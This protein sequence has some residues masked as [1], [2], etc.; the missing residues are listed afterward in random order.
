MLF[1]DRVS[2]RERHP[3]WLNLWRNALLLGIGI[4]HYQLWDGDVLMLYAVA[5]G[6][7]AGPAPP[8][9]QGF[10]SLGKR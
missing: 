3:N 5:V 1:I 2:H 4:L 8:F 10:D 9:R 6:V 7:P